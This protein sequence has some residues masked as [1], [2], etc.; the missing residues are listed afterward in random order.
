MVG[1]GVLWV[2]NGALDF[3]IELYDVHDESGD[4]ILSRDLCKEF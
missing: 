4:T 2:V 3:W 1:I